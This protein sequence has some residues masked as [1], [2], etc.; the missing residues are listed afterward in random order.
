MLA[1]LLIGDWRHDAPGD[2]LSRDVRICGGKYFKHREVIRMI[3]N[4]NATY[5]VIYVCQE[6]RVPPGIDTLMEQL[7][8][9]LD[10]R[11][12]RV[13]SVRAVLAAAGNFAVDIDAVILDIESLSDREG[14]TLFDIVNTITTL[15]RYHKLNAAHPSA[16]THPPAIAIAVTATTD[17][18]QIRELLNMANI[19]GIYPSGYDFSLNEKITAMREFINRRHHVPKS[20]K[21]LLTSKQKVIGHDNSNTLTTRQ[22]QI[23]ELVIARGASNKAIANI[24]HIT[25][26]TVKLHMTSILK[27]CGVR[28][29]TQLVAFHVK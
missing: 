3:I 27:K 6:S 25:D 1:L 18:K 23:L 28:S 2:V 20:V 26:S 4:N 10:V 7:S 24:L 29:R 5:H 11:F 13:P 22:S 21:Q 14:A 16:D 12:E 19:S 9:Q 8:E 17:P 15:L